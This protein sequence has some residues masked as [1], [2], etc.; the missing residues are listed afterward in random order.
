MW[1]W[2]GVFQQSFYDEG[3]LVALASICI[4]FTNEKPC[5]FGI[6]QSPLCTFCQEEDKIML[7]SSSAEDNKACP[8]SFFAAHVFGRTT[9]EKPLVPRVMNPSSTYS[10]PTRNLVNFGNM[11]CPGFA[12][13]TLMLEN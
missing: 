5:C 10:F 9:Q 6:T 3:K 12:T 7:V 8:R 4:V 13:M 11:Y 2:C 1:K